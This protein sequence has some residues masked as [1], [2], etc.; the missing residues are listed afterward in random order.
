MPTNKRLTII[1][2]ATFVAGA[3]SMFP[4]RVAYSLF[5]PDGLRLSAISGSIWKG[6][7]T[8]GQIGDLYFRNLAW[9]FNPFDLFTGKLGFNV[10]LDPAGGYLSADVALAPTGAITLSDVDGGVSI[11][12]LQ[13]IAPLPGIDGTVRLDLSLLRLEDGLPTAADGQIEISGLIARGLSP[14]PLGDFRA[15]LVSTD[16]GVS[17]SVEDLQGVL[18]IAGS[19]QVS[20]DRTYSLTGLVAAKPNTPESV[21]SQLQFL[22]SANE[23]GQREFRFE[24]QL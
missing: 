19:L 13:S 23:R 8:E 7:A 9:R 10:S 22:G 20:F 6:A 24:G 14:T 16:S 1:A 21:T 18:D 12:A 3:V 17:G 15:L 2:V 4:A 5:A 11:G